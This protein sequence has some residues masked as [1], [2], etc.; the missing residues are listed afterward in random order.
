MVSATSRAYV[1]TLRSIARR[2]DRQ[3]N[4]GMRRQQSGTAMDGTSGN[5]EVAYEA[6]SRGEGC[7]R[8]WGCGYA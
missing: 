5:A 1:A 8:Q 4:L 2:S 6:T 7:R 3:R